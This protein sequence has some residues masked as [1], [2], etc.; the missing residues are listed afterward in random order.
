MPIFCGLRGTNWNYNTKRYSISW[1][2]R[3]RTLRYEYIHFDI[4]ADAESCEWHFNIILLLTFSWNRPT[5]HKISSKATIL[6]YNKGMEATF[7]HFGEYLDEKH[8]ASVRH[9]HES[10]VHQTNSKKSCCFLGRRLQNL[11]LT[12]TTQYGSRLNQN[13]HSSTQDCNEIR[14]K[15]IYGLSHL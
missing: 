3:K 9:E 7:V 12:P 11:V 2:R 4:G 1:K 8:H 5:G 15:P 13:H 14:Q 6:R 10:L